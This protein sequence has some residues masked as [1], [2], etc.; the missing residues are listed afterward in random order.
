MVTKR[1][2]A[3]ADTAW[4]VRAVNRDGNAEVSCN[5]GVQKWP[6]ESRL[7]RDSAGFLEGSQ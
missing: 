2:K 3:A 4:S 6:W 7:S 5:W 1:S